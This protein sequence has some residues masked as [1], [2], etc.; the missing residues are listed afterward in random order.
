VHPACQI[1]SSGTSAEVPENENNIEN[2]TLE[3]LGALSGIQTLSGQSSNLLTRQGEA[4]RFVAGQNSICAEHSGQFKG[5]L[6]LHSG[7]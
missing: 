6:S 3:I 7:G 5:F 1:E 4:K 2:Q